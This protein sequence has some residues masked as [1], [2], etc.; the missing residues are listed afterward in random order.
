MGMS[1]KISDEVVGSELG[2]WYSR[3]KSRREKA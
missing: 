3:N 1:R 2:C